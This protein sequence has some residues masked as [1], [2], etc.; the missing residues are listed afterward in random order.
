MG[1]WTEKQPPVYTPR[2]IEIETKWMLCPHDRGWFEPG[3]FFIRK[4][5]VC[6]LCQ[7]PRYSGDQ[8]PGTWTFVEVSFSDLHDAPEI[9]LITIPVLDPP[10]PLPVS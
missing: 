1:Y 8:S 4:V 5:K 9:A 6:R 3:D 10:A 2:R 7:M